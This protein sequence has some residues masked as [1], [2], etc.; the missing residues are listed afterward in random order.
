MIKWTQEHTCTRKAVNPG[1]FGGEDSPAE[2]RGHGDFPIQ[3]RSKAL[4]EF[5]T[6]EIWDGLDGC[7]HG[8]GK[9]FT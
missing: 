6:S 3:V 2:S 9:R 8:S 4:L 1:R 7:F 5:L